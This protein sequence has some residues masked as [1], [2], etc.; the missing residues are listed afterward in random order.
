MAFPRACALAEV[1]WSPTSTR[2][3]AQFSDRLAVHLQ[4]L[5]TL[6]VSYRRA[7]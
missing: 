4:R 3:F 7:R 1:V 6:G 2:D 5:D